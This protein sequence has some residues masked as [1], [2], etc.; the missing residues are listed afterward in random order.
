MI[1][2]ANILISIFNVFYNKQTLFAIHIELERQT[3]FIDK[4]MNIEDAFK[5]H[6]LI[7]AIR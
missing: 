6:D 2:C 1:T 3:K 7:I 4:R 5:M